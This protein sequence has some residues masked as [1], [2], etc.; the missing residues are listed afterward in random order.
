MT[1]IDADTESQAAVG[2]ALARILSKL[3]PVLTALFQTLQALLTLVRTK[4]ITRAGEEGWRRQRGETH[5][6]G[7]AM[8]CRSWLQVRI[9]ALSSPFR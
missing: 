1:C 7:G 8:V 6:R 5:Q 2:T 9:E 3:S 4:K